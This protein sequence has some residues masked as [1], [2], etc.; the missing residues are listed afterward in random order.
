MDPESRLSGIETLWS[1]V[2]RAHDHEGSE[3]LEAQQLLL[4]QYGGAVRRYLLGALRNEDA[5]D[6]VFQEFALKFVRGDFEKAN[7]DKGRFRQ[8]V[9]T[10]IYRMVVDHQRRQ[11]KDR[12]HKDL[13]DVQADTEPTVTEQMEADF[14]NSWRT[15]LMARAWTALEEVQEKSGKPYYTV[16]RV[17]VDNPE[18]RSPEIAEEL[19]AKLGR[20][21]SA[22][23]ARV[24]I[25]RS[26][27]IYAEKLLD[28]VEESLHMRSDEELENELITLDLLSYCRPALDA[29]K[30][31]G[32]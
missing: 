1:V 14:T 26:R 5:A 21:I 3:A 4:H 9:K 13:A 10:V 24:L 25:H 8:F 6:E 30:E 17:R 23:N 29:R 27:E 20:K 19:T 11:K 22:G 16:L 28:M 2:R 7:P 12:R 32:T 31:K 15:E 18:M